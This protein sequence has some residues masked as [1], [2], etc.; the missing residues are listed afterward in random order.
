MLA[1]VWVGSFWSVVTFGDLSDNGYLAALV[2][3]GE[4]GVSWS[5]GLSAHRPY[6]DGLEVQP[7]TWGYLSED[8]LDRARFIWDDS[9]FMVRI[10]LWAPFAFI[11]GLL[12]VDLWRRKKFMEPSPKNTATSW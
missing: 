3:R 11:L 7:E 5:P 9:I 4:F 6:F 12:G 1:L 10:P 8:I 2:C